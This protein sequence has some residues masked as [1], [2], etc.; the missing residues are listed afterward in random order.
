[1]SKILVVDD[2]R[3]VVELL[4]FLLL[5]DGYNII[6][7]YSGRD[8]ISLAQHEKPDLVILDIMMPGIDGYTVYNTLQQ[9]PTTRDI[10]IIILTAKGQMR[11]VFAFASKIVAYIDKPFEP[12]MLREKVKSV[13]SPAK[14]VNGNK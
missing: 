5:K 8:A 4:N 14:T 9:N 12:K 10:P 13:L 3:N 2:E 7:A 1:M 6:N 11:D